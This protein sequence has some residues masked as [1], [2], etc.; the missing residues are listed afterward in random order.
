MV[1]WR[2]V[3]L[4]GLI[5]VVGIGSYVHHVAAWERK[6]EFHARNGSEIRL[7]G[8]DKYNAKGY[9]A[10]FSPSTIR[11]HVGQQYRL[12][13]TNLSTIPHDFKIEG[14]P[15]LKEGAGDA[16]GHS[17]SE[18]RSVVPQ[19]APDQGHDDRE[20][21]PGHG[22]GGGPA[23]AMGNGDG[24]DGGGEAGH[25]GGN[26]DVHADAQAGQTVEVVFTPTRAGTYKLACTMIGH[27]EGGMV[28]D[29]IVEE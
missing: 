17:A 24:N 1:L 26:G 6:E 13:F 25:G 27:A 18:S 28:T 22:G 23:E 21:V 8:R 7:V 19:T 5:A 12:L 29:V 3:V 16:G 2:V 9:F 4:T 20:A 15:A 10:K 11:L 14:M